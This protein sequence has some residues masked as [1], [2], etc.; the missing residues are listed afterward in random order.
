MFLPA[1]QIQKTIEKKLKNKQT[2][3]KN[4]NNNNNKTTTNN[5]EKRII[6]LGF[7]SNALSSIFIQCKTTTSRSFNNL[8]EL[9][10]EV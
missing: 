7:A 9:V 2:H 5:T 8:R 10:S 4:N 1:S 6:C 3:I